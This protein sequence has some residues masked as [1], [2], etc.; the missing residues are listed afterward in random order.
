MFI[1]SYAMSPSHPIWCLTAPKN[2]YILNPKELQCRKR[3]DTLFAL[4]NGVQYSLRQYWKHNPKE[5]YK[6]HKNI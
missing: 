1:F 2:I 5:Y 4:K 3:D 6:L